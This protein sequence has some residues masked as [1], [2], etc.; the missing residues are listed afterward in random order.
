MP[1]ANISELNALLPSDNF[2]KSP[3]FFN[4]EYCPLKPPNTNTFLLLFLI[5]KQMKRI[6][7]NRPKT[8]N[9]PQKQ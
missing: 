8:T 1:S 4:H 2:Q 7:E 3:K 5:K 9:K 6:N